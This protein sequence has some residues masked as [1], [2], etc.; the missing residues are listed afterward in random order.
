MLLLI[1]LVLDNTFRTCY[2]PWK[3]PTRLRKHKETISVRRFLGGGHR[4]DY[5]ASAQK[6][7]RPGRPTRV[8]LTQRMAEEDV[9]EEEDNEVRDPIVDLVSD[10]GEED[11]ELSS[12]AHM[13]V[14]VESLD[15]ISEVE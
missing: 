15:A 9:G 7:T 13:N 6:R 5:K 2:E 10:T 11:D 1:T 8:Q 3:R 14:L 4:I 12:G